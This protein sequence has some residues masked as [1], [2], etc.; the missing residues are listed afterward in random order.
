MAAGAEAVD[1]ATTKLHCLEENVAAT[2][3]SLTFADLAEIQ[4]AAAK[5]QIEVL[6]HKLYPSSFLYGELAKTAR[7]R[8]GNV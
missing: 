1:G 5:I 8:K 7:P 3:I 4:E 2:D 6:N